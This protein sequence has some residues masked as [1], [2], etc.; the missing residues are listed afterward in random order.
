MLRDRIIIGVNDKN[1]QQ[2]LLRRTEA[3]VAVIEKCK[4]YEI[5]SVNKGLLE[6]K[7]TVASIVTSSEPVT[8]VVQAITRYCFNCGD[9]WTP[10][11][12]DN[13]RAKGQTCKCCSKSGHFQRMCRQKSKQQK[14]SNSGSNSSNGNG[15]K[16]NNN[17]NVSSLNWADGKLPD[18]NKNGNLTHPHAFSNKVIRKFIF[19]I[20]SEKAKWTKEYIV[21]D[22]LNETVNFKI[23]SG[24]DTNCIPISIVKKLNV[25]IINKNND[26]MV[27][28]YNNNKIKVYG[29]VELQCFDSK[30]KSKRFSEFIV[31]SNGHEPILGL[32]TCMEWKFIKRMDVDTIACAGE[33]QKFIEQNWHLF[34]ETGKF[35]GTFSIHLYENSKPILHYIKRIPLA[36]L[37][38]L[39]VEL[40]QMVQDGIISPVDYPTDWVNN[41]QVVE[42]ASGGRLRICLDPKPLNACIKREH[43]L[44]P[45]IDDFTSKL[46]NKTIFTVLDLSSAFWHMELDEKS[47]QLT[48]FMTPFGR[49]KF[50]R[51]AYGLNCAPEMFQ[52]KMIQIFGDLEGVSI[53]FDDM[54]IFAENEATHDEILNKIIKRVE[55]NNVKFSPEKIQF[56]RAEVKFMGNIISSDQIRPLAKYT[57][58]ILGMKKPTDKSSVLRFL[59]LLKYVARFIP[60]LS[61]ITANLRHLTRNDVQFEWNNEH[62]VE[63]N[64]LLKQMSSDSVLGIYDPNKPVSV[65]TDA[66]RDGLGCVLIQDGRPIAFASR[67]LSKSEQKWAQ[68]EKELLA[69]VFACKRFHFFLYGREFTVESDHKPLETLV[70]R[71]IDDVTAR[72]Q[73]MFMFLLKYP[74]MNVVYKPGRDM[75]VADC[76]SRAQLQEIEEDKELSGMIHSV[77]RAV[78]ASEDNYN[79][80]RDIMKRDEKYS[81]ICKHVEHGWP[82]Y[83]QLDDFSQKFHKLKSEL[84]VENELLFY[85][86][87]LVIPTGLQ[88]K[89]AKWLHNP[90]LGI[91]K[92]LSRARI[93]YYWPGMNTQIREMV[94][95]SSICEKFKRNNQKEP[96]VQD[97]SPKYPF[98]RVS[99]D[100]FEYAGHDFIAI[101]DAY[102]NYL[103]SYR[104]KNKTSKHIIEGLKE[105]FDR[106]GYPTYVRADNVP[107]SSGEFDRFASEYNIKFNFSS[108][109]YPQS[110]GLSEKAVAIAKNILKRCYEANEIDQFQYRI[111]EYNTTPV[112][113]M[114]STPSELFFG[115]LIKSKLPISSSLLVRK[116]T[117][118]NE[119]QKIIEN[120][121]EKQR[122]YY[123]RYAKL[124]SPLNIDDGV[125]FKKNSKEWNYGTIV[126]DVNGKSYVIRDSFGH[127]FRRNRRFIAKTKNTGF[128]TGELL[129]E[130]GV[131][132]DG[133]GMG[134]H[135]FNQVQ[136][137]QPMEQSAYNQQNGAI[138]DVNGAEPSVNLDDASMSSSDEYDTADSHASGSDTEPEPVQ[139]SVNAP[140]IQPE[141]TVS[142]YG[143]LRRPREMYGFDY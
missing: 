124:L 30:T 52:R 88:G 136:I 81:R 113:S 95:S 80:Y 36:L 13:C 93:L 103:L 135:N 56:K 112:A 7:Q 118:E 33:K 84:H 12:V 15:G 119:I 63:F 89:I 127:H 65:Q 139:Q 102:S 86:H 78:C 49:Y 64:N 3:L 100:L 71:D 41:L 105:I 29:T 20:N 14:S 143:R 34:H 115:R 61:K 110:N 51:V 98:E 39:R 82:P 76:L 68:M 32:D 46:A 87:R 45:T 94:E 43:F 83:H 130:E 128:D 75:L 122:F 125:I 91:E 23:D 116:N 104:L 79:Y 27:F 60:N 66:S 10:K 108:P 99:M 37:D 142:R 53:Y 38:R 97:E 129:L 54:I 73:R 1:L 137:V 140:P 107:F 138:D 35:P 55:Q 48:T 8:Q 72:L 134:N 24:S 132:T 16:N 50:N 59:G 111:L 57:D 114:R 77:T 42:R 131:L 26:F 21:G 19:R 109:R 25:P 44:I 96:L 106:I 101:I 92:T 22:R 70:K 40:D 18:E 5:A 11:H 74:N 9:S 141:I 28:D 17:R 47:S 67:T 117:S 31:V 123:D 6:S 126:A 120:K 2:N 121:R 4:S 90:H 85:N 69:I 133:A 62:E 58:A